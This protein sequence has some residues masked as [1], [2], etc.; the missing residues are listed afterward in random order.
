MD[1]SVT[2]SLDRHKAGKGTVRTANLIPGEGVHDVFPDGLL[3]RPLG[4]R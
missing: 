1:G 3:D 4:N 2:D